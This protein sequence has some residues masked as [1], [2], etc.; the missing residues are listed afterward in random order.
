MGDKKR[1]KSPKEIVFVCVCGG[2]SDVYFLFPSS[3]A[4][5]SP[6]CYIALKAIISII[7]AIL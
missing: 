3:F 2:M 1:V 4:S 6:L 7:C 5:F